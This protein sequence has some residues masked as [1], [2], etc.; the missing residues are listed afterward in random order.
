MRAIRQLALLAALV[1]LSL[2]GQTA[3]TGFLDRTV[4]SSGTTYKYQVFVP[5]DYDPGRQWPVIVFLHGAGERGDD[6]LIQ[7]EVGLGSALR[8]HADRFPAI[9]VFPQAPED[10]RWTEATADGA[11]AAL[12]DVRD[13]FATDPGRL[14]LTGLSLGGNG[15]WYL[16]YTRPDVWAAI[17]PICGWVAGDGRLGS[18]IPEGVE[19]PHRHLAERVGGIPTWIF[20][21]ESDTVVPVDQSRRMA[22]AYRA[23]GREVRYTELPGTG[24]NS[25]DAA[26]N[27]PALAAWLFAQRRP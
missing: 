6:G 10:A 24:H 16:A 18:F 23:A 22:D 1:P 3:Q 11:M 2:P 5:A 17:V 13:E 21:G 4:Q 14:Y 8:R 20:H 25:W 9:V 19:D 27:S 12:S 26:Y 15:T 7:T